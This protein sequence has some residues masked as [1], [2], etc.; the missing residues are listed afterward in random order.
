MLKVIGKVA[1]GMWRSVLSEQD[2]AL[3]KAIKQRNFGPKLAWLA[4]DKEAV[5]TCDK[6]GHT[7]SS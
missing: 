4:K 5:T 7:P 6:N 1:A 3:V 2:S